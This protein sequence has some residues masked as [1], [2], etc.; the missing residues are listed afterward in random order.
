MFTLVCRS[1][2]DSGRWNQAVVR[3]IGCPF[4][5]Y[6][7]SRFSSENNGRPALYF[8]LRDSAG[9]IVAQ[10][11]GLA[12]NKLFARL[13]RFRILSFGS[14]PAYKDP[15]ALREMMR[16]VQ[17]FG[18]QQ[19]FMAVEWNSFGTPRA[20]RL[21]DIPRNSIGQRRWEFVVDLERSEENLW[22]SLH[23]KKRN[24]I[25]KAVN[26]ALRIETAQDI[27][28]IL[29]Y[30]SLAEET[31]RRKCNAGIPFPAPAGEDYFKRVKRMLI[32]KK[33]GRMVLAYDG[34][35][36]VAG[37]LFVGFNQSA[38]YVISAANETGLKMSAPDLVLWKTMTAYLQEGYKTF[39]LGGLSEHELGND[40]LEQS[41]LYHFKKRFCAEVHECY[42]SLSVIR[43]REQRVYGR[44]APLKSKIR[45]FFP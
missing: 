1:T 3:L 4:H 29:L 13:P 36:P 10:S 23:G 38:Y 17:V 21:A 2:V 37:A 35:R 7:W 41:G 34:P 11:Y 31:W 12:E 27:S 16:Q 28:Q 15:F 9:E 32:D 8:A 14:L 42:K 43:P 45:R 18:A 19:G 25:R 20:C 39:N 40:P 22:E 44:L 24:L 30:R 26:S 5:S 33:I 6:E